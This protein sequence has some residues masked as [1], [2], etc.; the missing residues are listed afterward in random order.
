[1]NIAK[2]LLDYGFHP[3]TV[4]FP[5]IVREALMIEPTETESRETLDKFASA[6]IQIA[7]EAR[8][9]PELLLKAPHI[10]PSARMDEV[11]AARQLVL[12]CRPSYLSDP[13][14]VN[15]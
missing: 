1:M 13:Q 5:L 14:H 6:L 12:C 11:Q 3:P 8:D 7:N 4:Y 10:T 9:E 15:K 2:R